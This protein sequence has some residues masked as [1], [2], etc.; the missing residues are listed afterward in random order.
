MLE[1]FHQI[2]I[3]SVSGGFWKW[4]GYFLII[5]VVLF[6][7]TKLL[8]V[9]LIYLVELIHGHKEEKNRSDN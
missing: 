5:Y 1:Q 8:Q 6:A 4:L 7:P 3:D 2:L 9:F